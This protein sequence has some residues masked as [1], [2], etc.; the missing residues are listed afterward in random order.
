VQSPNV[1]INFAG[2]LMG[3]GFAAHNVINAGIFS[4]GNSPGTFTIGGSFGQNA[5]GTLVI[6]VAGTKPGEHDLVQIGGTAELGGSLRI[7]RVDGARLKPGDKVTFL[8][9]AAGVKGTFEKVSNDFNTGTILSAGIVYDTNSVSLEVQQGSFSQFAEEDGMTSNQ[10][11]VATALDRLARNGKQPK[12]IDFLNNEPLGNLAHDFDLIAPEELQAIY[13]IGISQAN[14]Q[15]ANLQRRMSEIRRGNHG[16]SAEGLSVSGLQSPT[17]DSDLP[18]ASAPTDLPPAPGASGPTGLASKEIRPPEAAAAAAAA[19]RRYGAF[20]T[21]VGEWAKVGT[22]SEA[23]GYDLATGGFTFGVDYRINEN[24]AVGINA[25][26]ARSSADLFGNG[27]VTVDGAKL[28][29]YGTYHLEDFYLDASVQGGYNSYDTR[30]S[31]LQGSPRGST[32]GGEVNALLSIGYDFNSERVEGLSFG[33]IASM[34]YTYI[35]IGGFTESGSLAPLNYGAQSGNSF[36]TTLGGKASYD[37]HLGTVLV[38]PELR[39]A[40]QHEYGDAAFGID[41]DIDGSSFTVAGAEIGR[42]S[43]LLGAG[44]AVLFN[45]RMAAYLYY[46]GEIGRANY[47]TNNVSG[48]FRM[49]F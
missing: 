40:W 2:T 47:E 16:F 3:S 28:G 9:A 17:A 46:D 24:L 41:A 26:Y 22:T 29:I 42:D 19:D 34:Q 21:G 27:N 20:I 48:G 39:F 11:H 23:S 30:R 43:L 38:R 49:N 1:L 36:R 25:G 5:A 31:G 37:W 7:T 6:E 15:T 14:V 45:E 18:P 32:S 10:H 44:V 12:L 4:P 13:T 35:G 8:T 33:P